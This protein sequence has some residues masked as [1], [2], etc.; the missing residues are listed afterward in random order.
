MPDID[1]DSSSTTVEI[2]VIFPDP[3]ISSIIVD[4]IG[5]SGGSLW[6]TI[7]GTLS[8]QDDLEAALDSKISVST[9]NYFNV[10][11]Y[12]AKGDTKTVTDG[13][14]SSGSNQLHSTIAS[15]TSDDA[16]KIAFVAGAGSAGKTLETSILS[17][18]GGIATLANN[19]STTVSSNGRIDFGTLDTAAFNS[20]IAALPSHGGVMYIPSG[21]Y[22]LG[23]SNSSNQFL[24]NRGNFVLIGDGIGRSKLIYSSSAKNGLGIGNGVKAGNLN[25]VGSANYHYA[26][27]KDFT[28]EDRN[29]NPS[30]YSGSEPS[31]ISLIWIEDVVFDS[32][33]I[34]N[35]AGNGS[36]TVDSLG[37]KQIGTRIVGGAAQTVAQNFTFKNLVITG[38]QG[39]GINL[40]GYNMLF[41]HCVITGVSRKPIEGSWG[42]EI[43]V[44]NCILSGSL[45]TGMWEGPNIYFDGNTTNDIQMTVDVSGSDILQSNIWFTNNTIT[46]KLDL[47]SAASKDV[48]I[49]GNVFDNSAPIGLS[50]TVTGTLEIRGNICKNVGRQALVSSNFSMPSGSILIVSDNTFAR[51]STNVNPDIAIFDSDT[52]YASPNV[53]VGNNY[54]I[55]G[56]GKYVTLGRKATWLNKPVTHPGSIDIFTANPGESVLVDTST[57]AVTVNL[58]TDTPL[59]AVLGDSIRLWDYKSNASVHNITVGGGGRNIDGSASNYVI[60]TDGTKIELIFVGGTTGWKVST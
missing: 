46:G 42:S 10:T 21:I 45:T 36:I 18:S 28:I 48:H 16:G 22:M 54:G 6:G 14:I 12:G 53:K 13:S 47:D 27:F 59:S 52:L 9:G 56:N 4:R 23:T 5:P 51:P 60:S 43:R 11:S 40:S 34:I 58:D 2:D 1:I 39:D 57:Y 3:V 55:D 49:I 32:V 24:I 41:D 33:E 8:N 20:V 15:F 31:G 50:S 37:T 25:N 29:V 44:R 17:V 35:A 26:T 38:G 19:A 7:G 30:A